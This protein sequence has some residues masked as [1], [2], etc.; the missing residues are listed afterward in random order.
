MTNDGVVMSSA[1]EEANMD[2]AND[3]APVK[4]V[5]PKVP[6]FS[7]MDDEA[8]TAHVAEMHH[9]GTTV[10]ANRHF[11]SHITGIVPPPGHIHMKKVAK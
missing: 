5:V 2:S 9:P 8:K 3:P 11:I 6:A 4:P 1:A 7:Q 10:D